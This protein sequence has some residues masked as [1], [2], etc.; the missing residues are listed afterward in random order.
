MNRGTRTEECDICI[1]FDS[2]R[3]SR[4]FRQVRRKCRK[5]VSNLTSSTD[6]DRC[7][8]R[9]VESCVSNPPKLPH[10]ETYDYRIFPLRSWQFG[11][12]QLSVP[13]LSPTYSIFFLLCFGSRILFSI[14]TEDN[15]SMRCTMI[16]SY[17]IRI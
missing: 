17:G 16:N 9:H 6:F 5:K 10:V 8:I 13:P 14:K 7:K 4:K 11:R 1:S 3:K 15:G 2:L 12:L